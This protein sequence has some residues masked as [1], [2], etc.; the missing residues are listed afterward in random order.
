MVMICKIRDRSAYCSKKHK[1]RV[2]EINAYKEEKGCM[3]CGQKFPGVCMDFDHREGE[4]KKFNVS[5]CSS[6]SVE[7]LN[8]EIKKC[9]LV[10]KNC[11][12]IRTYNKKQH[13]FAARIRWGK[14]SLEIDQNQMELSLCP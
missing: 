11:H 1:Q 10:C 4:I 13:S 6:Y 7:K 12:A 3:D 9:D 5:N 2:A 8:S 14:T